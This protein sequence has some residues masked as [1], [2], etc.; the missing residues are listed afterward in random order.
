MDN[1]K[2]DTTNNNNKSEFVSDKFSR[3]E[4]TLEEHQAEVLRLVNNEREKAGVPPL[5]ADPLLMEIAQLKAEE[6]EDLDYFGHESP[7]YGSPTAFAKN[8][9]YSGGVGENILKGSYTPSSV[10]GMLMKSEAHKENMLNPNYKYL[11]V[12][13]AGEHGGKLRLGVQMFSY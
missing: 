1:S 11:G 13:R 6:M 4:A 12:G 3:G 10:V 7:N 5:E 9:G 2:E 8:Y